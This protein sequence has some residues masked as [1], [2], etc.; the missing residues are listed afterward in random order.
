MTR[1][2]P[3]LFDLTIIGGG[4]TGLFGAFYA[5]LRG[6]RTK[7]VDSL[8]QL[9]GQLNALYPEK[10]IYDVAGFPAVLAKTLSHELTKQAMQYHPTIALNQQVL[11]LCRLDPD[12]L[13]LVTDREAHHSRTVL[14]AAGGGAFTPKRLPGRE[15][16]QY[17]GRGLHYFIRDMTEF[18]RKSIL[19]VGGGDSAVDWAL[20]LMRVTRDVTLIHRRDSFRAHEDSVQKLYESPVK[21]RTFYE[22]RGINGDGRVEGATIYD[23]RTQVEETLNVDAVLVNIGFISTLGPIRDWGLELNKEGIVVTSRMETNLPG[24]F[25]AGDVVSYPG[26]LKLIATGFGEAAIAVN[27][28]KVFIDPDSSSFP[29]H[30]STVVPKQRKAASEA[31]AEAPATGSE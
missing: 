25:A 9:G 30:S 21:V 28:A 20:N 3:E 12:R 18:A 15:Y 16:Q 5:G 10:F 14:I 2:V 8:D 31:A 7:I 26:K 29:G 22:L 19:V 4:P 1:Q 17:E 23:N 6:M 13:E 11:R 24:V 27:H